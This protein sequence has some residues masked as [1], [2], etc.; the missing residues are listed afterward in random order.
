MFKLPEQSNVCVWVPSG[1]FS[2]KL[3]GPNPRNL[4]IVLTASWIVFTA[5]N[6]YVSSASTHSI[7]LNRFK[8]FYKHIHSW[9]L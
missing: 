9:L 4:I 6:E 3:A 1:T 5:D 8:G 7:I 2:V